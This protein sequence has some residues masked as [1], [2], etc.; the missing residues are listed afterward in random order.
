MG[1]VSEGRDGCGE[2]KRNDGSGGAEVGR[3]EG[4]WRASPE[5][6]ESFAPSEERAQQHRVLSVCARTVQASGQFR[7]FMLHGKTHTDGLEETS[8]VGV[9]ECVFRI[10]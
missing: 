3:R 5:V 4:F 9:R 2:S 10:R 7:G 1:L 6:A 8:Q